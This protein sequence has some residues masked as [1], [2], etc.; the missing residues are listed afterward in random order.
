MAVSLEE[1]ETIIDRI[2]EL[3]QSNEAAIEYGQ[4]PQAWVEDNLPEGT[5]PSDVAEAMSE[6]AP[7]MGGIHQQ[8]LAHYTAGGGAAT[9]SVVNEISYSY[10][11]VYQQN[12]FIYA[13]EGAQVT[14]IQGDGNTTTQVDIDGSFN[15]H[16]EVEPSGPEGTEPPVDPST[17]PIDID[18]IIARGQTVP[19]GTDV[20][21]PAEYQQTQQAA[22][23]RF[24]VGFDPLDT[25]AGDPG[26]G[27]NPPSNI[28]FG[29]YEQVPDQADPPD[30]GE[31][32]ETLLL[33]YFEVDLDAPP[34]GEAGEDGVSTLFQVNNAEAEH[35]YD[36]PEPG[37]EPPPAP[38]AAPEPEMDL[39]D[40]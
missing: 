38:D 11:T 40:A 24:G 6:V 19:P 34:E 23:G 3:F 28:L 1:Q 30:A 7:R 22:E 37:Y 39:P 5:E 14:N 18:D 8:N 36:E 35:D 15:S 10:N 32:G 26:P 2:L 13:E 9:A 33:P 31:G 21:D 12:A 27:G 16:A 20:P 29:E 25:G 17:R 4:D